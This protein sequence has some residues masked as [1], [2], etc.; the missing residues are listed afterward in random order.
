M[1]VKKEDGILVTILYLHKSM[2]SFKD[3]PN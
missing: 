1:V 2:L 3:A